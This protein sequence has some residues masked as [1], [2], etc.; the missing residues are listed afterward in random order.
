MIGQPV[1]IDTPGGARSIA[2]KGMLAGCGV[3]L[4]QVQQVALGSNVGAAIIAGRLTFGVLH[5]DDVPVIESQGKAL[6]IVT[7]LKKTAP[8]SHYLLGIARIDKLAQNRDSYVRLIASLISAAHYMQDPKNADTI[9]DVAKP[10][11]RTHDEAKA[12]LKGYV[13]MGFW[14][15]DDD[16]MARN[17]LDAVIKTQAAVGGIAPGKTPVTYERLVDP[18]V[19]RDADAMFKKEH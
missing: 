13:A 12:A 2:L 11:G 7:T 19:W 4:D 8:N 16:G 9:A 17:K 6:T 15:V 14:A 3:K 10:T 5:L 1:G 18:T